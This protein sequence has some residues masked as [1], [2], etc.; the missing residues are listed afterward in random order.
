MPEV[1]LDFPRH[2]VEFPDPANP[3]VVLFRCDLT[4][5]TSNW[6]CIYGSGCKGVIAESPDSGCCA[7][8]AHFADNDDRKR[9][10]A[11][12]ARLTPADWEKHEQG[13]GRKW[14]EK[15]DDGAHKTAII[16]DSCVFSNSRDFAN[17][18]GCAFHLL[19]AREGVH[20][21]ELKPDV[22]W[23]LPISRSYERVTRDD[24]TEVL[25]V[26]VTEFSRRNWGAG[27]HS[28]DWYCSGN[29]E[30]HIATVPV[31]KSCRAELVALIG[32]EAYDVLAEHCAAREALLAAGRAQ[33][34]P[35]QRVSAP[36][37]VKLP[38]LA[39]H[40]ADTR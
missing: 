6:T 39:P 20:P 38:M 30:A 10:T 11:A 19:A 24:G 23:Q 9:V 21:M 31:Y 8:G 40:L 1:D 27:G 36:V 3:D 15:D 2:W 28:L 18:M 33:R 13:R 34:D 37:F 35:Q 32:A 25:V 22:C 12:V 29:T 7:L 17:G 26:S 5:L 14:L 16:G 4:W